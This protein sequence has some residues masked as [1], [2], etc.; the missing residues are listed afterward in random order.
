[1]NGPDMKIGMRV[2]LDIRRVPIWH[3]RQGVITHIHPGKVE[4]LLDERPDHCALGQIAT[5]LWDDVEA[6]AV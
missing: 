2:L 5:V 1:M 6:L 3:G 4:V